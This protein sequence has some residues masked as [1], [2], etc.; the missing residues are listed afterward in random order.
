VI[1]DKLYMFK[2]RYS[3]P[4]VFDTTYINTTMTTLGSAIQSCT[5]TEGLEL[6]LDFNPAVEIEETRGGK[7]DR[8][9]GERV[10]S[11]SKV[12]I[13]CPRSRT[14]ITNNILEN[15]YSFGYK[16]VTGGIY[17][18]F[19]EFKVV[20]DEYKAFEDHFFE[21]VSNEGLQWWHCGNISVV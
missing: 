5:L 8:W 9:A 6:G 1:V 7:V 20:K 3:T 21:F 14:D 19:G 2:Y 13:I 18:N 10:L 11:S 12:K 17:L 4:F 16:D 15:S